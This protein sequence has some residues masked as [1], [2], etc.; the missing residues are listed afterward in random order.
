M[1]NV[2]L[3]KAVAS[4]KA[5]GN[6]IEQARLASILW[7]KK[8]EKKVLQ[9]LAEM[10]NADGGFSYFV[11]GFSSVCDTAYVLIW[12]DELTLQRHPM[13]EHAVD[14]LAFQQK[15]DCGWD[16]VERVKETNPPPFLMPGVIS[17]RIWLTAYCAH[18]IIRLGYAEHVRAKGC[19]N[20]FLKAY[21]ESSGR[22]GS[23]KDLRA[24]WDWLVLLAY[25]YG[26]ESEIFKQTLAV[27]EENFAPEKWEGNY[28]AWLC[29]CLRDAGL[30]ADYP[31]VKHCLE[32]LAKKQRADGSWDS[33]DGEEYAVNATIEALNAL[34]H[35]VII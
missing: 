11:K 25:I 17:N 24:T 5:K 4:V 23:S 14:F 6:I 26:R 20:E 10:Q 28:M 34:K 33:E 30:P 7:K 32:E 9:K 21:R 31:F 19:P 29:L 3:E 1:T 8:P 35:Y 13:A 15:E 22:L 27:V 18:W 16:E 2:D 12:F